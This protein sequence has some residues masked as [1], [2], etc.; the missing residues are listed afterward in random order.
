V[1]HTG[2]RV[3]CA[4]FAFIDTD[5]VRRGSETRASQLMRERAGRRA[6]G[7]APLDLACVAIVRGIER[8][9]RHVVAP[10]W[11]APAL[12]ARML[13]QP[14]VERR[15]LR[16]GLEEAMRAAAEEPT[17]LTTPQE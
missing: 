2:T 9:A 5:M 11:V 17:R 6:P 3:G 16:M 8:R 1:H 7:W 14:V 4:Y 10:R 15:A 12:Y 13:L